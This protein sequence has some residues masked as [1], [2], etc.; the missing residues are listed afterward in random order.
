MNPRVQSLV[1][2]EIFCLLVGFDNGEQRLFDATPYLHL[3][4]FRTLQNPEV[5]R[6]AH[7]VAGAVEWPGEIDLSHDTLY[8]QSRPVQA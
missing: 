3:G 2:Q 1:P 8:L 6:Q 7:V 4:V 5:F